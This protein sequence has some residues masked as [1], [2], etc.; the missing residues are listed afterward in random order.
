MWQCVFAQEKQ[1]EGQIDWGRQTLFEG[2]FKYYCQLAANDMLHLLWINC[3]G[4]NMM[5]CV[6]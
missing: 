6:E 3:T 4:E 2:G 5:K 1:F